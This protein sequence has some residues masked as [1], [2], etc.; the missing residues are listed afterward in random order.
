MIRRPTR[1]SWLIPVTAALLLFFVG[2]GA[3]LFVAFAILLN[4]TP[5]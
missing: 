2:I 5:D 1:L 3:V 4:G